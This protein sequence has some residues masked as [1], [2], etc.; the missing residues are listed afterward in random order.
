MDLL[1]PRHNLVVDLDIGKD[2]LHME[3]YTNLEDCQ[4]RISNFLDFLYMDHNRYCHLDNSLLHNTNLVGLA[5]HKDQGLDIVDNLVLHCIYC[6]VG[7][8]RMVHYC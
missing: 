6:R 7:V 3:V 5:N 2:L 4:N 8:D 1:V